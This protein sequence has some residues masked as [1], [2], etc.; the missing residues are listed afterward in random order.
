MTDHEYDL[1]TAVELLGDHPAG[2]RRYAATVT[3]RWSALGGGA[4][5]GYLLGIC[6]RAMRDEVARHAD[7][8]PDP[9]VVSAFFLRPGVTGPA[10]VHAEAVRV[11]R[12]L[13]TAEVRLAQD[14]KEAVRAVA[15]F[16]DLGAASGR[17][18]MF[19]EAPKLPAPEDCVDATGG[20]SIPGLTIADRFEYRF[21]EPPGW[22]RGAPSG[23]PRMEFWVRFKDGREP[24]TLCLPS[25]VDAA[26]PAVVELGEHASSTIEL[27]AHLRARPAPGW[28][29][30]R[31]STSYLIDGYHEEDFEVWD[32][33]GALVAQGRQLALLP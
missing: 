19:A 22:S 29:A 11:G 32:S 14:G 20:L 7:G 21:A 2:G 30:C 16:A 27:T 5:G 6:V 17:T 12:R 1:D 23:D 25:I 18:K 13:A 24:D 3:D 15:N 33:K 26:A 31:V 10:E 8:R 4:N 28:L 9:L